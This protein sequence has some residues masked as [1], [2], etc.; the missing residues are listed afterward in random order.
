[1]VVWW[2]FRKCEAEAYVL[3]VMHDCQSANVQV[4]SHYKNTKAGTVLLM[5][6]RLATFIFCMDIQS[7]FFYLVYR[8]YLKLT[9]GV[10]H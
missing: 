6:R 7:F 3:T 10:K 2:A 1:M 5:D 9:S 4:S 8:S